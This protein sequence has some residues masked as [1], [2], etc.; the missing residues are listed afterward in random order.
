MQ[1]KAVANRLQCRVVPGC[2][3]DR[4]T[5]TRARVNGTN[6]RPYTTLHKPA[7]PIGRSDETMPL[8]NHAANAFR[9]MNDAHKLKLGD[10]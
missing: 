7:A 3:K 5:R 8:A 6:R 2:L 9:R 4:F 1:N 10:I